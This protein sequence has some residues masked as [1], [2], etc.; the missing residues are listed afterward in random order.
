MNTELTTFTFAPA[1]ANVRIVTI[2]GNPWFVVTD[3]CRIL[4]VNNPLTGTQA[5]GR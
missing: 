3:V 1:N 4:G 2:D 5:P